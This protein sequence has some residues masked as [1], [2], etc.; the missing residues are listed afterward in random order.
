MLPMLQNPRV[1]TL[2]ALT[3]FTVPVTERIITAL[4]ATLTPKVV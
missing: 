3:Y 1:V 4:F 2:S